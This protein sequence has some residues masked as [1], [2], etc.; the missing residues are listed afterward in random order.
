MDQLAGLGVVTQHT[1]TFDNSTVIEVSPNSLYDPASKWGTPLQLGARWS[2]ASPDSVALLLAYD[3]DVANANPAY[4]NLTG[5]DINI[6]GAMSSYQ[7]AQP[8]NL[9]SGAYNTVS[10]T[11]YTSSENA[12]VVPYSVLQRMVAAKN[13]RIRIHTG[14][15]NQDADFSADHIPGGKATAITSIRTFM[16]KVA[17][18][19]H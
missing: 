19:R 7:A 16:A 8:T 11:I 10:R 17:A 1:S 12:V 3:S 5:L 14:S 15:G 9:S 18:V 4:L 6:D 2:S 13:C